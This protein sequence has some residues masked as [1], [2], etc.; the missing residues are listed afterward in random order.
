M[1]FEESAG[2]SKKTASFSEAVDEV[3]SLRVIDSSLVVHHHPPS[4]ASPMKTRRRKG[5]K[6]MCSVY[7]F[8]FWS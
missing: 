5:R 3:S 7:T 6:V 4:A 2:T 8:V 1:R